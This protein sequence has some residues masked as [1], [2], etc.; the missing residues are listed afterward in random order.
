MTHNKYLE[1][2]VWKKTIKK[3]N[4]ENCSIMNIL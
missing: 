4:F 2:N 3:S 1:K